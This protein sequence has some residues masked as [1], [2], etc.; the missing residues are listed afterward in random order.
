MAEKNYVRRVSLR[1]TMTVQCGERKR[2]LWEATGLRPVGVYPHRGQQAPH[3]QRVQKSKPK[4]S[5][6]SGVVAGKPYHRGML[7]INYPGAPW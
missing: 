3:R 2:T 5:K 7:W 1:A 6:G 4:R